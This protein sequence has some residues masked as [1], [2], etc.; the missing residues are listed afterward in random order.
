MGR[1]GQT[2]GRLLCVR[3]GMKLGQRGVQVGRNVD[4]V[5]VV[6]LSE[7]VIYFVEFAILTGIIDRLAI[8]YRNAKTKVNDG[9]LERKFVTSEIS[10]TWAEMP[11]TK[12]F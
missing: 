11:A 10:L 12:Y 2:W 9:W 6:W 7:I 3:L 1:A 4:A 5:I 8:V